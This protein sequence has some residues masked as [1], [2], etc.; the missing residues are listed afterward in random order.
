[1]SVA[2][3]TSGAAAATAP[4]RVEI[5]NVESIVNY[6]NDKMLHPDYKGMLDWAIL[7]CYSSGKD[8]QALSKKRKEQ[9]L[10]GEMISPLKNTDYQRTI[11]SALAAGEDVKAYCGINL[12]DT[13]KESQL[14]SG[15]FA[16][17]STG[18]G[19]R[20]IN[21]HIWGII[22]LYA[23]GEDIPNADKAL[24]W[25]V[26]QQNYDGGFS[27]DTEILYSDIDMTA[28]AIVAMVCLDKD[29]TY[30]PIQRALAYL[31]EQQNSDGSMGLWGTS[32]TE[33]CAQLIQAL[34]MLGIDPT[35][36]EWTKNNGNPL[37]GMLKYRLKNGAFSH[38]SEMIPS[39]MATGQALLAINDYLTGQSIYTKLRLEN[40]TDDDLQQAIGHP[41]EGKY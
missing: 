39:E 36:Q 4:D 19:D 1:M 33:S 21:A 35:G 41:T 2:F 7:G 40:R 29:Q 3:I 6:L 31:K 30:P 5:E 16:D 13:V 14:P 8:V 32:N 22:A 17:T 12:V 11:F 38:S 23:V 28:M 25:L 9:V 18:I 37:T 20:L 15:K 24:S 10:A 26:E 27:V 34:V